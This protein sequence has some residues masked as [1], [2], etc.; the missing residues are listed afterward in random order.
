[1]ALIVLC[2]RA[3]HL[4]DFAVEFDAAAI[5]CALFGFFEFGG[6]YVSVRKLIRWRIVVVRFAGCERVEFRYGDGEIEEFHEK[7]P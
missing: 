3:F 1:M 7:E 2:E 5:E 4:H 6:N